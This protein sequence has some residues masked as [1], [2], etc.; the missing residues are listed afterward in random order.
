MKPI[1]LKLGNIKH[2]LPERILKKLKKC[3]KGVNFYPQNYELL[4]SELSNKF[5]VNKKN[6]LL[7]N[8]I[9]GGIDLIAKVFGQNILFFTPTYF[10]FCEAARRNGRRYKAINSFNGREYKINI[11]HPEIKNASLIF[12]C[13]PNNPFGLLDKKTILNIAKKTKG[14]V[15]IDECYADFSGESVLKHI[16]N[17]PNLLVLRSFS[18]GYSAAGLRLGFILGNKK[19]INQ[20]RDKKLFY[21]VSSPSI[22]AALVLLKEEIYFKNL[23]EEIKKLKNDFEKYLEV[24]RFNI[25]KS[26]TNNIIIKFSSINKANG[27]YSFLLRNQVIVNQGDGISTV[28][29]NKSWIRLAC[30]TREQMNQLKKIIDKSDLH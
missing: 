17:Y 16:K 3:F 28:G 10:E 12:L 1:N 23:I 5:D 24:K 30:G 18:K 25:I 11:N 15:A 22:N 21:D 6:I 14:I 2:S 4:V 29:L 26:N 19:L 27:F 9:D 7:V 20:L 8:G 13:N